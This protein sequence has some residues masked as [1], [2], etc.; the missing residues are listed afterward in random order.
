MGSESNNRAKPKL[1]K[2]CAQY[3]HDALHFDDEIASTEE[4]YHERYNQD[5]MLDSSNKEE[6]YE[7]FYHELSGDESIMDDSTRKSKKVSFAQ[8]DEKFVL[9]PDPEVRIIPGTK[10]FRFAPSETHEQPPLSQNDEKA[11]SPQQPMPRGR[12][13]VKEKIELEKK[14][15]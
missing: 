4:T 2:Q 6:S 10:M 15:D 1:N 7:E 3:H 12:K 14:Y 5:I 8:E 13:L 11:V 9:Q